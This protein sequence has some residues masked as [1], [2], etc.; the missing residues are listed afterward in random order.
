MSPYMAKIVGQEDVIYVW[1]VG[2]EGVGDGQD[3][4]VT[5]DVHPDSPTYGEVIHSVSVGGRYE[6]HHSG[7]TDDRRFLWAAAL[8]TSHIF[9]FDVHTDPAKP[10]LVRTIDDFVKMRNERDATL[11]MPRLILPSLQVN[12]RAGNMPPAD[13]EGNVFLK[14]PVNKL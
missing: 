4:L 10:R 12:M 11:G 6:A 1:T 7:F 2:V 5:V 9:I 13:D 14:L 3:K 8:D